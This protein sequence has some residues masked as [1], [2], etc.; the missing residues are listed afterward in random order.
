MP[1]LPR[2][3]AL[4]RLTKSGGA[5]L[6]VF[7]VA[8]GLGGFLFA[9]S[10]LY[11][12]A[13]SRGH[14]PGFTLALE[15]G[16]RSSVRTHVLGMAVPDLSAPALA[17]LGAAHFQGGCAPCHGAPGRTA[18]PIVRAMLPV[19]PDLVV[20]VSSWRPQELFW[21]VRHG[22]KYTGMPAWPAPERD[23]EVWAVVAFLQRLPTMSA[24]QYEELA[25]L[26]QREE[27]VPIRSLAQG[28]PLGTGIAACT[29]CHGMDGS[30]R[31]SGAFP[32]LDIQSAE[33]LLAQLQS[34]AAGTRASGIM[35]PVTA[36]LSAA[37]MR[38]L[39]EY[40]GARKTATVEPLDPALAVG[41]TLAVA[42]APDQG[43]PA[44]LAC[45]G[46]DPA[47]RSPLFP[48]L[49]GQFASF[50][51][52]QLALFKS[53]KYRPTPAADIMAVIAK[54]L[55]DEEIQAVSAYLAGDQAAKR[56]R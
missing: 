54:R 5:W 44:C 12:V 32:R 42:G 45:H 8:G 23:D 17:E 15:F 38:R 39:A 11:S 33:Y 49:V 26:T 43:I 53:G 4:W 51:A 13:A 55:S 14:W 1:A 28:G 21:I 27:D 30:G 18:N 9:W 37:E 50:T 34:Y 6:A 35:E 2:A 52:A 10:G 31:P 25:W 46:A 24:A 16:L 7:L 36:D 22:L 19:P 48:A 20:S 47:S 40:S 29:R 41:R 3:E 56:R